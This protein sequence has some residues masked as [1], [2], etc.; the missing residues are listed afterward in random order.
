MGSG[1]TDIG[2]GWRSICVL[3]GGAVF[4]LGNGIH[5]QL[6]GGKGSRKPDGAVRLPGPATAIDAG[7]DSAC[8]VVNGGVWCWGSNG[9]GR[10]GIGD[11][12]AKGGATPVNVVGLPAGAGAVDIAGNSSHYCVLMADGSVRLLGRQRQRQC[13]QRRDHGQC[14]GTQRRCP[15]WTG[16]LRGRQQQPHV[17]G[18]RRELLLLGLQQRRPTRRREDRWRERHAG[19]GA[20]ASQGDDHGPSRR[21]SR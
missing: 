6:G 1:V 7:T 5:G 11:A 21:R 8:A 14:P 13:R 9:D 10:L 17:C 20:A 18:G 2:A 4:C 19:Q 16:V 3:Q 12:T 15:A